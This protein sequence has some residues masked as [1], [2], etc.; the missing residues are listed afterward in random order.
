MIKPRII[1]DTGVLVAFLMGSDKFHQWSVQTLN[2]IQYPIL[3]CEPVLT[4]VCF[5]L[6]R[7]HLGRA[8]VLQLVEQA[9][10]EIPFYLSPEVESIRILMQRY[11][12]VPMSLADACLVKMAEIYT[13]A[14]VLTL[15]SD[16]RIYRKHRNQII[17]LIMP[18]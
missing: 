10:L 18:D 15:D 17:P 7:I 6:Q 14:S 1:V 5:L 2:H 11:D 3:T 4:E 12:S 9:Y 16:F 13:D 8:K